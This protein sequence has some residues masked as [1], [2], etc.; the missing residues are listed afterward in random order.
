MLGIRLALVV[1]SLRAGGAERVASTLVN[2]WAASGD[3][4]TLVTLDPASEDF[5]ELDARVSRVSLDAGYKS[6]NGWQ[7]I[8]NCMRRVMQ[9]RKFFDHDQ[10]DL[11]L[12]F[13]DKTNIQVLLAGLSSGLKVIA[14]EH[15]DPRKHKIGAIADGLRRLLYR[16]AEAIVVLTAGMHA[17]G[18]QIAKRR[19]VYVIPNPISQQFLGNH[20]AR[21]NSHGR[22]LLAMGRLAPQKG[23]D[24]LLEAFARCASQHPNWTLRLIGEGEERSRLGKIAHD[25]AIDHQVEFA[26]ITR[27]PE[28]AMREADL[29]VLSSRYEGFPM[30][31]LEAMASG[32]PVISFDC[33]SGPREMI[34]D[35][36]DG[37][38]VP[39]NNVAELARAMDRLMTSE[40]ERRR[41]ASRGIEITDRFGIETIAS[42]W[43][44]VFSKALCS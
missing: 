12:S 20:Q 21:S 29:F 2:Y 18:K 8:R 7:M 3:D 17:W 30:V 38:L 40:S 41:L 16:R 10:F 25:L 9:L 34:R 19:P 6:F 4:V 15:N 28:K 39:P 36:V 26:L 11:I 22:I 13:G 23:F 24:I 14:A 43:R 35:E 44:N 32:L 1:H 5:Y 42:R 33:L 27:R 37:I 31:L